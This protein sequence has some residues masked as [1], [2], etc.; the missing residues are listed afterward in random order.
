MERCRVETTFLLLLAKKQ[1][2]TGVCY[3]SPLSSCNS[4]SHNFASYKPLYEG[5]YK[6]MNDIFFRLYGGGRTCARCHVDI[7]PTDLVMKARHCVFHVD[8]FKCATCDNS[9]RK[10]KEPA[11]PV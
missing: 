1:I 3:R 5:L 2:I 6:S 7:N 8:C 9:L 11:T 10:G 4:K